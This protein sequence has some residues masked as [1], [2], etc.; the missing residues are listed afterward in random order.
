MWNLKS[1]PWGQEDGERVFQYRRGELFREDLQFVF[2]IVSHS[3]GWGSVASPEERCS[4]PHPSLTTHG[5][6]HTASPS[7]VTKGHSVGTLQGRE[8]GCEC[9]VLSVWE[10]SG[11]PS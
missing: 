11:R 9:C 10:A 5:V 3:G 2:I 4:L 7:T 1:F 8:G 6:K